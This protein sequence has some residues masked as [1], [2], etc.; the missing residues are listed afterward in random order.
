MGK[1]VLLYKMCA[2]AVCAN[3]DSVKE[4]VTNK[5]IINMLCGFKHPDVAFE[6]LFGIVKLR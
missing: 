1:R 4:S 5:T 6:K 3:V 2:S